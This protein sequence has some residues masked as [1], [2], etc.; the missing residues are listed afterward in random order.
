MST[1]QVVVLVVVLLA[2][3]LAAALLVAQAQR[4]RRLQERF[5][6]EYDHTLEQAG[7]RRAAEHELQ[8]RT[9]RREDLDVRPLEPQ[10]RDA[11][12][13][14]WRRTQLTFVDAPQQ[15]VHEA[16]VL[17]AQVM[18]ERGYPVAEFDQRARDVSVD[19]PV[20][21]GEYRTAHEIAGRSDR[22]EA[23]TEELRS[24]MVHYR[25]L[26]TELLQVD[27]STGTSPAR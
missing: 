17:V 26:F 4:R 25:A 6:S 15:A 7:D 1:T 21:V 12:A 13:E 27:G 3:A 2:L 18:A 20:V 5:G 10:A 11:F 16:D 9:K 19:H 22:G 14:Q 23:T 24:A 8:E